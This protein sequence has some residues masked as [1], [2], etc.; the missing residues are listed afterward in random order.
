[1]GCGVGFTTTTRG[2][3]AFGGVV[4][5][6]RVGSA[7]TGRGC[8]IP[9][10]ETPDPGIPRAMGLGLAVLGW[11]SRAGT[12]GLDAE[13]PDCD[14]GQWGRVGTTTVQGRTPR[15]M[16]PTRCVG[17]ERGRTGMLAVLSRRM[18]G[19]GVGWELSPCHECRDEGSA[20]GISESLE[21]FAAGET[22]FR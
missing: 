3:P 10:L 19:G 4:G 5:R 2:A 1:M 22:R 13:V 16:E 20:T 21:E 7:G 9:E 18:A 12:T 6:L 17:C 15:M 8:A 11:D 14:R